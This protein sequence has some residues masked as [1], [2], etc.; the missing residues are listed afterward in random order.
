MKKI[1]L[2]KAKNQIARHN[3]IRDINRQIVL[4][5]VRVRSTIS[6]AEIARETS[7]QR[8]TVSAIVDDLQ[9]AGF[10]EE[11]GTGDS[12]GGRKP[13]L[14]QLKTGTPVAIGVDITPRE[15]TIVLADLAGNLLQKE[16]L[17]TSSD[18]EYMNEQILSRVKAIADA[19]PDAELEVGISIPGIADQVTGNV[20]YVPYFQ[21]SNW[22]IGH[23]ITKATGLP[24]TIDNDANAVALAELW[25]GSEEVKRTRNFIMVMISEGIGT[26]IVI[27]GE[28]YRGENGAAGEFGHMYVGE[29]APVTCSCGRHDCWEAH[30]SEKAVVGRYM[31]DDNASRAG[32]VD[33]DHLV[34]LAV[35]GEEKAIGIIKQTAN[36]LGIGVSN[37]LIG[38]SPQAVVVSGSIV[39]A[40][41]LIKEDIHAYGRRSIR[42]EVSSALIVPSTLGDTPTILGSISL[43]LARKFASAN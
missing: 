38:F 13:T 3:T 37:L 26:G 10:I 34:R 27:D 15:T 23:Q 39:K 20:L 28:V 21:W 9:A 41:D 1:Y 43:V 33:M 25:F 42:Q 31:A 11:I 22:D 16:T 18:L 2:N 5:Y 4:N 36:Y 32:M 19:H 30:A 8:S 14:L 40:W 12:T 6:R 35:N 17:P 29:N 24:V 7:L